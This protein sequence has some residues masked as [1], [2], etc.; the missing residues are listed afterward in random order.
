MLFDDFVLILPKNTQKVL[1]NRL[2]RGYNGIK[3]K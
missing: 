2:V 1:A 3:S